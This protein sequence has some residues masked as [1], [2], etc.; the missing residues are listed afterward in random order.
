MLQLKQIVD[1]KHE[2]ISNLQASG[3]DLKQKILDL[4]EKGQLC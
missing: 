3:A 4:S 1:E 2:S